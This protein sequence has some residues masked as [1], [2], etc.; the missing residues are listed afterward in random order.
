MY[1]KYKIK[2][3]IA[4]NRHIA[5][6]M[7]YPALYCIEWWILVERMRGTEKNAT[8]PATAGHSF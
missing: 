6:K 8:F 4:F 5:R 3:N 7:Q 1:K 2:S